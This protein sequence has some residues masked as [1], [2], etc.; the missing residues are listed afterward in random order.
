MEETKRVVAWF[1]ENRSINLEVSEELYGI[2][3]WKAHGELMR[4]QTWDAITSADAILFGATGSPQYSSIPKEHWLPDNLLRIRQKLG[5]FCNLRPIRPS[6]QLYEISPLRTEVLSGADLLMVREL[7]GGIYFNDPR[8]TE[9]LPGGGKRAFNTMAYTSD[10]VARIAR[11]AFQLARGR[12]RHLCSVDKAN[13]LEVSMLWRDVVQSIHDTEFPDVELQHMYVD[14]AAM[15][16]VRAP[17]QFDVML[18]ENLF[19]DILSDCAAMVGGSIGMLPSAALGAVDAQ[20]R[21]PALYEPIHGSAPDIA[22]RGIANPIG[23][24]MS[25]GLCM[26]LTMG[27]AEESR[28]LQR[29]I[30]AAIEGGARTADIA[31]SGAPAMT[32]S[33]MGSAI[34]DALNE[35]AETEN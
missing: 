32:T 5:L 20:G 30:D 33:Q 29:A 21:R 13:V 14:N 1:Q 22:G 24:I 4:P 16:L 10:E 17:R 8:G 26:Q 25:F 27:L 18:T 12:R 31:M 6:P 35:L 23:C 3:A 34:L 28:F 11:I 15:Q 7:N 9:D 19:G 2:D